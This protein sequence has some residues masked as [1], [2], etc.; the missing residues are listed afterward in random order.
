MKTDDTP[1]TLEERHELAYAVGGWKT[2]PCGNLP[3][4][5]FCERSDCSL[6][7]RMRPDGSEE[8][9]YNSSDVLPLD[10]DIVL[11]WL[12]S[13]DRMIHITGGTPEVQWQVRVSRPGNRYEAHIL[14]SNSRNGPR[15]E[16]VI[17]RAGYDIMKGLIP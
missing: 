11:Q 17:L 16:N 13:M 14:L 6:W 4:D 15:L 10:I 8:Y 7:Y 9:L 1:L 5:E 2:R 12:K 3:E